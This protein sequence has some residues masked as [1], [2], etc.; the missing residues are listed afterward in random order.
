[1]TQNDIIT[2]NPTNEY[3][4]NI[5]RYAEEIVEKYNLFLGPRCDKCKNNMLAF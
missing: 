3:L 2:L 1:M 4:L 5:Y